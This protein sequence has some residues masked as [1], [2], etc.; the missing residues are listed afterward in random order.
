[1]QERP[2]SGVGSS[3]LDY[4]TGEA[5]EGPDSGVGSSMLAYSTGEAQEEVSLMQQG[6]QE[7]DS[8][9]E[10]KKKLDAD[11][12]ERQ[13]V[14]DYAEVMAAVE[15]LEDDHY[16]DVIEQAHMAEVARKAWADSER[17]NKA[18]TKV[19]DKSSSSS[20]AAGNAPHA[21]DP[22]S[23]ARMPRHWPGLEQECP[24]S[25]GSGAFPAAGAAAKAD[26]V[27]RDQAWPGRKDVLDPRWAPA[28]AAAQRL[29]LPKEG[30]EGDEASM[31]QQDHG[32]QGDQP[33]RH[34]S[35]CSSDSDGYVRPERVRKRRSPDLRRRGSEKDKQFG[36][37]FDVVLAAV[38]QQ[39]R[40]DQKDVLKQA[41]MARAR[42]SWARTE[43][44]NRTAAGSSTDCDH[45]YA[46][47]S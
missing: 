42:S 27:K 11:A 5:K 41:Q 47:G 16:D 8:D 31:M 23:G 34:T 26:V 9:R 1:M 10:H 38:E 45:M 17:K 24:S 18:K 2:D 6:R 21:H 12:V 36:K 20:S 30:E 28:W 33:S 35:S 32:S 3:M 25:G 37:D 13:A 46:R 14:T 15:Q 4:S 7:K 19:D 39:E 22:E 40:D 43:E 44:T 29:Q